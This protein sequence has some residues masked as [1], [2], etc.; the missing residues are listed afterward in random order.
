MRV[1]CRR[2]N[3]LYETADLVGDAIAL[4]VMSEPILLIEVGRK[5]KSGS[6]TRLLYG[7]LQAG[8]IFF[9]VVEALRFE[10]YIRVVGERLNKVSEL[11]AE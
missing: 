1:T 2:R 8:A 5:V 4:E 9:G 11:G 7:P 3:V 10:A 6:I